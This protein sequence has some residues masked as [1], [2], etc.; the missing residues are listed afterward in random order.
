MTPIPRFSILPALL[1]AYPVPSADL[2]LRLADPSRD[3]PALTELINN[4]YAID[5]GSTGDKYKCTQ[6]W[7]DNEA[8]EHF[9]RP[10]ATIILEKEGVMVGMVFIQ[11]KGEER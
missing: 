1:E 7:I 2:C 3:I 9:E 11:M 6:R 8:Q 10:G 4:A 5:I